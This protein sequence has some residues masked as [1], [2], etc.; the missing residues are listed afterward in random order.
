MIVPRNGV[1]ALAKLP[2]RTN[3]DLRQLALDARRKSGV[4]IADK[5]EQIRREA[6]RCA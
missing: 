2:A 3:L 6:E 5:A 4:R 1:E